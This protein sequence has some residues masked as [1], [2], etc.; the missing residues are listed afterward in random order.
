MILNKMNEP[1]ITIKVVVGGEEHIIHTC[2]NEYRSLMV[3]IRDKLYPDGFG[4]CGGMGRCATCQIELKSG[5]AQAAMDR[6]EQS[7]LNKLGISDPAIRLSCQLLIEP[8]LQ[9]ATVVVIE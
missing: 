7:T 2:R 6:N 4:E 3:L 9:D 5:D 8:A 1:D